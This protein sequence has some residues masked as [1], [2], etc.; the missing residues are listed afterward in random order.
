MVRTTTINHKN[1]TVSGG[2]QR[3]RQESKFSEVEGD[4]PKEVPKN[5]FQI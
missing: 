1:C 4:Q 5:F 3:R 2:I